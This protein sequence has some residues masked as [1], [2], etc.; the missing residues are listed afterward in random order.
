[1]NNSFD[2]KIDRL[3]P[4]DLNAEVAVLGGMLQEANAIGRVI[5]IFG[6]AGERCFY[7]SDHQ[8]I[9]SAIVSQFC[10]DTAVDILT[11]SDEL[12][13]S[14][15]L[16]EV[17][18]RYYLTELVARVPSAANIDY[19]AKIVFEKANLRRLTGIGIEMTDD[20]FSEYMR[21]DEVIDRAETKIFELATRRAKKG[22]VDV[23]PVLIEAFDI[24][25]RSHRDPK[26]LTGVPTG[27]KKLDDAL[28]GLQASDLIIV[29]GRPGFGKTTLGLNIARNAAVDH[30]VGVGI[31]SLEMIKW[32][33]GIRLICAEAKVDSH[34][35]RSGRLTKEHLARI[36]AAL[37]R[38]AEAPIY[39]DDTPSLSVMEIRAKARRL[40]KE[41]NAGLFIIDYLQI[42]RHPN[43]ENRNISIGMTTQSLKSLAKEL[44]VPIVAL[45]QL[46]RIDEDARPSLIDLRESGAIEQDSDVVLFPYAPNGAGA[47][48]IGK[49]RNGPIL[50]VPIMFMK[51][52]SLFTNLESHGKGLPVNSWY[53]KDQSPF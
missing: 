52:Y 21:S 26:V 43:A 15:E 16:D 41:K 14:G 36:N 9:Y 35:A 48:I 53:D 32:Q 42:M 22:F 2:Y 28:N 20:A 18:G 8:K 11:T 45:S 6:D 24:V 46:K 25:D 1:M 7:K 39:I 37:S 44:N 51:E 30:K 49:Q 4:Q 50:D 40:M 19:H 17:G 23:N 3:P 12:T 10:R 5:E 34:L 33:L 31:F 13:K 27:F 29:A 47:I 38:L